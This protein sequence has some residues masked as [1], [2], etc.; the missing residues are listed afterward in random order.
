MSES[1]VVRRGLGA[2]GL[3]SLALVGA[4]A[5]QGVSGPAEQ[6]AFVITSSGTT[7]WDLVHEAGSPNGNRGASLLIS[8]AGNGSI[9]ASS[10]DATNM[11]VWVNDWDTGGD[12]GW[13]LDVEKGLGLG[14]CPG[15]TCSTNDAVTGHEIGSVNTTVG[16]GSLFLN[17]SAVTSGNLSHL[18]LGSTQ[19]SEGYSVSGKANTADPY[20]LICSG[21]GG[22]SQRSDCA[23]NPGLNIKFLRFDPVAVG[24][25]HDYVAQAL[26]FVQP[27]TRGCTF[28]Q[29]YWKNHPDAWPV[30]SLTLGTVTYTKAQLLNILKEPVKGNGLVSLAHQLIAAKLNVASG[31][32][33]V[34]GAIAT[35][36][37]LIGS[38]VVPPVGSGYL[39]PSSTGSANDALDSFNT[40]A[41]GPG[42]C[43]D[44]QAVG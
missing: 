36:D 16:T 24:A 8:A 19:T 21:T 34:P 7:T 10:G 37:A 39:A 5:E 4:C 17:L 26:A 25:G 38:R 12:G 35:A 30:S 33:P 3:L 9:T 20:T 15:G 2:L 41:T 28:T 18:Y 1:S 27:V 22:A 29:G 42:H 23:V 32:A 13:A 43:G 6:P 44:E 40:G 31:A 11:R 14:S